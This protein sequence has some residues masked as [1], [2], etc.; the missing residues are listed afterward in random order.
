[1]WQIALLYQHY[2]PLRRKIK[3]VSADG[4]DDTKNSHKLQKHRGSKPTIPQQKNAGYWEEGPT[5][6]RPSPRRKVMNSNDENKT[7][8]PDQNCCVSLYA[9]Y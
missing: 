4:A 3:Q 5:E 9:A 7:N 1:V 8:A 6:T 2:F